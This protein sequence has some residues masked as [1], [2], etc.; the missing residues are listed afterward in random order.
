MPAQ[1]IRGPQIDLAAVKL[2]REFELHLR[3]AE[4][5]RDVA[6]RELDQQID[7]AVRAGRACEPNTESR[8]M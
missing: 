5:A 1:V 4:Q 7:V 2:L 8:R 6:G 3:N